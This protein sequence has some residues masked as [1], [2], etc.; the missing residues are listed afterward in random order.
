MFVIIDEMHDAWGFGEFES[1]AEA[2]AELERLATIPWDEPPNQ[3]PCV[4]WRECG[5]TYAVAE[6]DAAVG[7]HAEIVFVP[8]LRIT[9]NGATW[10]HEHEALT[11]QARPAGGVGSEQQG[12]GAVHR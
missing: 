8:Y 5:P 7:K 4:Q 9:K 1:F 2:M 6:Y 3:A 11:E 12:N 10:L